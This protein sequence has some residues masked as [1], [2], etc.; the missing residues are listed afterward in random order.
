MDTNWK[1]K[2]MTRITT[3][4]RAASLLLCSHGR[5]HGNSVGSDMS[6]GWNLE[7]TGDYRYLALDTSLLYM[8]VP[9]VPATSIYIMVKSGVRG[10]AGLTFMGLLTGVVVVGVGGRPGHRYP[11]RLSE[12]VGQ[13]LL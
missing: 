13:A 7:V 3:I 2:P 6:L 9:E 10:A 12:V 8:E 5:T 4:C 11:V 1:K